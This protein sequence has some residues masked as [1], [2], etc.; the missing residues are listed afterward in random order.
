MV[1]KREGRIVALFLVVYICVSTLDKYL[2]E[3]DM[4]TP[5]MGAG[6]VVAG[7]VVLPNTGGNRVIAALAIIS[8]A[9]GVAIIISSIARSAA[10]KSS[11]A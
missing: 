10:K 5:G 8:I 9:V 3:R 2:R 7:A 1:N 11:K 6:P 4:Y